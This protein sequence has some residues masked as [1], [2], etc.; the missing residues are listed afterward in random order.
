LI[1]A[2]IFLGVVYTQTIPH[3]ITR[4][5]YGISSALS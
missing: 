5:L 2:F 4:M 1:F 3:N